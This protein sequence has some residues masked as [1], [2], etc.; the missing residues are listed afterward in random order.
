MLGNRISNLINSF[1]IVFL[2]FVACD[3]TK[4]KWEALLSIS[5]DCQYGHLLARNIDGELN[6]FLIKIN[7]FEN[8]NYTVLDTLPLDAYAHSYTFSNERTLTFIDY[9]SDSIRAIKMQD[10]FIP[11][12]ITTVLKGNRSDFTN[13][14]L[15]E[16]TYIILDHEKNIFA[17]YDKS[18]SVHVIK[19]LS[20]TTCNILAHFP[21]AFFP[22]FSIDMKS[23]FIPQNIK[24]INSTYN[25]E[26]WEFD[27]M[28]EELIKVAEIKG[29]AKQIQGFTANQEIYY[30]KESA[31]ISSNVWKYS[32]KLGEVQVTNFSKKT[33]LTS[34]KLCNDVLY[35]I[36]EKETEDFS[37]AS[38]HKIVYLDES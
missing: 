22:T 5:T 11:D 14:W 37:P 38:I 8:F 23:I 24:N 26:V 29:F 9:V 21:L 32:A 34:F 20:Q 18:S 2:S 12:S 4:N 15:F 25:T 35:C 13:V 1:I 10:I 27:L 28:T 36:L 31:E 30:R 3:N 33:P 17:T 7:E 16:M 19:K 6:N